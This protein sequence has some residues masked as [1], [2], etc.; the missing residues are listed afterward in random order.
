MLSSSSVLLA[1]A[2]RAIRRERPVMLLEGNCWRAEIGL[3]RDLTDALP[4]WPLFLLRDLRR[5]DPTQ[6]S[7]GR[8]QSAEDGIDRG[9]PTM[10]ASPNSAGNGLVAS[11]FDPFDMV[12]TD[13]LG[14]VADG[15]VSPVSRV[16]VWQWWTAMR[17]TPYTEF[18]PQEVEERITRDRRHKFR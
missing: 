4:V 8:R 12:R 15:R 10:D 9:R 1:V 16:Y 3:L 13:H 14:R 11:D 7:S 5:H 17:L 18:R 6:G 2:V